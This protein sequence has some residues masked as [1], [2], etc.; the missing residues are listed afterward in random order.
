[1]A[2]A[3]LA[4]VG[5]GGRSLLRR[6]VERKHQVAY[7]SILRSYS[8]EL[9][10]GTARRDVERLLRAKG[11]SFEQTCCILGGDR[12]ALEDL[13]KIGS[14]PTPWYCSEN[15]VYLVFEFYSPRHLGLTDAQ[16]F[17]SLKRVAISPWLQ[18]CL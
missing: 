13:V 6:H 7:Q 14:E 3:A 15:D 2:T 11:Q 1:M 9:K 16:P 12:S 5:L 10:P 4:I 17:D 8:A 18:G